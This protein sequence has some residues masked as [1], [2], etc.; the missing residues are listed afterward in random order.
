MYKYEYA[1]L[2]LVSES[3]EI[4]YEYE[5][6]KKSI[7]LLGDFAEGFP[8]RLDEL[9]L[10]L[11]EEGFEKIEG[12]D[13]CKPED[14]KVSVAFESILDDATQQSVLWMDVIRGEY[15]TDLLEQPC[16]I[17]ALYN[18]QNDTYS[19]FDFL[20]G[21]DCQVVN[22]FDA[23]NTVIGFSVSAPGITEAQQEQIKTSAEPDVYYY[24]PMEDYF[25]PFQTPVCPGEDQ[26]EFATVF[27]EWS[28]LT[29]Y[30]DFQPATFS[31]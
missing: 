27:V 4:I 21:A 31:G 15:Y 16:A 2:G 24:I 5:S 3:F 18:A 28:G 30:A 12:E 14:Y 1:V 6:S 26:G 20:N 11:V 7:I 22:Y 13:E 19:S 29:L 23:N 9:Y 25:Y 17:F 10:T 8:E